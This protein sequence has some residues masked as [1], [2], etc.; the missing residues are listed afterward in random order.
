MQLC[1]ISKI[2]LTK[3]NCDRRNC[4][5]MCPS[6]CHA[7]VVKNCAKNIVKRW[8]QT[9]PKVIKTICHENPKSWGLSLPIICSTPSFE[10]VTNSFKNRKYSKILSDIFFP[11]LNAW[12]LVMKQCQCYQGRERRITLLCCIR[13]FS[14]VP[15]QRLN[16]T[17]LEHKLNEWLW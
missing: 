9:V 16:T 10:K 3:K 11:L 1:T 15:C 5:D 2:S 14:S 7:N 12:R 6:I 13:R 4:D 8:L 17:T